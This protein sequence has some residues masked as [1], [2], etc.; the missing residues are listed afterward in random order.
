[1]VTVIFLLN[2]LKIGV[3]I[4]ENVGEYRGYFT[5]GKYNGFG[6][7]KWNNG[8]KYEGNW[9]K[10]QIN[11][12]GKLTYANNDFYEGEFEGGKRHGEGKMFTHKNQASYDG[13][14]LYGSQHGIGV[15]TDRE[16]KKQSA[17]Y[18]NGKLVKWIKDDEEV[19]MYD[20]LSESL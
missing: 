9:T 2:L 15:V 6:I 18:S 19:N 14:W 13:P 10:G 7:Y 16:G 8:N 12:V 17:L 11:G 3:L 1:M 4:E 20:Q 5:K